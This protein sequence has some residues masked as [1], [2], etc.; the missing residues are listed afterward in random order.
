VLGREVRRLRRLGPQLREPHRHR[1]RNLRRARGNR[2]NR[3]WQI[4]LR[5]SD[6][7]LD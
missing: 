2:S 5:G 1:R 7:G 3:E 6:A 4:W